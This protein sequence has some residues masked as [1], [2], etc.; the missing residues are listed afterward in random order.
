MFIRS[1]TE[2]A[3]RNW[4][5]Y[6][7]IL[8]T[9]SVGNVGQLSCDA[10]IATLGPKR[11]GYLH[12]DS[13]LPIVGSD[14][15]GEGSG[16]IATALDVYESAEHKLVIVQQRA[17]LIKGRKCQFVDRLFEWIQACQFRQVVLLTSVFA[18][19]RRDTQLVGPQTRFLATPAAQQLLPDE[20]LS[21]SG[22]HLGWIHLEKRQLEF[23]NDDGS[24]EPDIFIP[25]SGITKSL[26][27]K[28]VSE[29]LSALC[30]LIFCA[31]GDNISDA[32]TLSS[33][34]NTFKKWIPSDQQWKI[35]P[36]WKL[37]FGTRFEQS[38]F[39]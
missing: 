35:P 23:T 33:L 16:Q 21:G 34:I 1:G 28:C 37:L 29:N 11:V 2:T 18:H 4:T 17:P 12:D 36:S 15:F 20:L 19:E 25:G 9:V 7:L 22:E 5:E 6:T 3:D 10:I 30:L 13:V 8:P 32:L 38:L 39:Q 27:S 14:P 31:E 24:L 26:F